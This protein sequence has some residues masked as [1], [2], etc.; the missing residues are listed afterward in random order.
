VIFG[1]TTLSHIHV[2]ISLIGILAGAVVLVGLLGAKRMDGWTAIF[3][4]STVLTSVTGYFFPFHKLM[5]SH[6]IGAISLVALA[7]AIVARYSKH[8][9]G[10]WRRI[11][12]VTAMIAFYLNVFVLVFQL[13][14]KVSALIALAPT[15]SE[16]PFLISQVVV[17][18][19]FIVFTIFAAKRFHEPA[20]G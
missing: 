2:L 15:Q 10:A 6:I 18:L 20:Q 12:V 5:P 13:F 11:Y 7:V 8:M 3:L 19:V 14:T 9:A 1:S 16:P 17:M 4:A